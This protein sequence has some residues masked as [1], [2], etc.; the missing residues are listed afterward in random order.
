MSD[1]IINVLDL[2]AD[3]SGKSDSTAAFKEA[4]AVGSAN[5]G[6]VM[7][8]SGT[9]YISGVIMGSPPAVKEKKSGK[10]DKK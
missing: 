7:V 4:V 2:G 6:C 10:K 1:E 3:P 9:Y 5:R 8:P